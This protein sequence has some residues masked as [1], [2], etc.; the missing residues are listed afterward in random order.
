VQIVQR[1]EEKRRAKAVHRHGH[2]E[3]MVSFVRQ[4]QVWTRTHQGWRCAG[5]SR[6]PQSAT[7]QN[8]DQPQIMTSR[9]LCLS[10]RHWRCGRCGLS[11]RIPISEAFWQSQ[12]AAATLTAVRLL[13]G[14]VAHGPF[15]LARVLAVA[16][17][18]RCRCGLS[19]ERHGVE[20]L[21]RG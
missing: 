6:R 17:Q 2:C 7:R 13:Y 14:L 3:G 1:V 12:S 11:Q 15:L 18:R 5:G 16:I 21:S 19:E 10:R 8:H 4:M 20:A 9:S